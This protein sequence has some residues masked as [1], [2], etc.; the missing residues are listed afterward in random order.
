MGR[1]DAFYSKRRWMRLRRRLKRMRKRRRK[2]RRRRTGGRRRR[3]RNLEEIK[4]PHHEG[5]GIRNAKNI[6]KT[7]TLDKRMATCFGLNVHTY[8]SLGVRHER[9]MS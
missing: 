9:N 2:K 1:I 8:R 5:W 3:R 6:R 7:A 4:Q